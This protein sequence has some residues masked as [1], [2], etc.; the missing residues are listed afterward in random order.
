MFELKDVTMI[1]DMEKEEKVYAIKNINL[2][3]P[4]KGLLELWG[5]REVENLH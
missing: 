5:L 2:S 3:F 1:Y 4:E